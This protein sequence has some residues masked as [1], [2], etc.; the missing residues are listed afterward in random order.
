MLSGMFHRA[1]VVPLACPASTHHFLPVVG[2]AQLSQMSLTEKWVLVKGL[3]QQEMGKVRLH[4]KKKIWG[5]VGKD[6]SEY[7]LQTAVSVAP[8]SVLCCFS[9]F[10]PPS[11][12]SERH[13]QGNKLLFSG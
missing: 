2:V 3:L 8:S 10:S 6:V 9:G 12:Y 4:T 1:L 5:T 7:I 13:N 11:D